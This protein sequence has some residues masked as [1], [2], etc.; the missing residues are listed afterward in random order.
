MGRY[1]ATAGTQTRP[2]CEYEISPV[3]RKQYIDRVGET[4]YVRVYS[5]PADV[6][7]KNPEIVD[8]RGKPFPFEPSEGI[9]CVEPVGPYVRDVRGLD[10]KNTPQSNENII[11]TLIGKK[12]KAR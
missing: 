3:D 7:I 5:L 10:Q 9:E 2:F 12:L 4:V 1:E 8:L 6:L 11:V